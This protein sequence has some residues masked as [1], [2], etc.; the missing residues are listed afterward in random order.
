MDAHAEKCDSTGPLAFYRTVFRESQIGM[1]VY[2]AAGQCVE[3]N[4][5]ISRLVGSD[6]ENVLLQNYNQIESWKKSGILETALSAVSE[7]EEKIIE[8]SV[9]TSYGRQITVACRFKPIAIMDQPYLLLVASDVTERRR[10]EEEREHL[11]QKLQDALDHVRTLRGII[12]ICATCKKIRDDEGYW[13]Q[14]ET[15]V[16]NHSHAEFSH[17][18]C[19]EC[20]KRLYPDF[21]PYAQD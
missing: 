7:N 19:P 1:A 18:I 20:A 10:V 9:T 17:G 15:Y 2:N 11:L 4:D 3:A 13:E 6:R 12:P 21:D 5:A 16:R 8:V 14:I